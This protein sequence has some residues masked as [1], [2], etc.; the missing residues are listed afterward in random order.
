M[1]Y[2]PSKPLPTDNLSVSQGDLQGNFSSANTEY[3][4]NHF[5]FDNLSANHGKHKQVTLPQLTIPATVS[6][7]LVLYNKVGASGS[8][9][10]MTRDGFGAT[11]DVPLTTSAVAKPTS[12]SKG[13]S[14]LAGNLLIQ[15]GSKNSPGASGIDTFLTAFSSAPYTVQLTP[16]NDGSHS[17]FTYYLDGAPSTTEFA[18]RGTTSGS[19]TLYWLAIGPA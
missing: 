10:W 8:E 9:L 6:G 2:Q 3:G 11:T 17:A 5:A 13:N 1:V 19:D 18:Y 4:I 16:R 12:A 7:D 14:W 15:W